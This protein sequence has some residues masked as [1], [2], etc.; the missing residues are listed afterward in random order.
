MH[1]TTDITPPTSKVKIGNFDA[2]T[3]TADEVVKSL[4]ENGGCFIRNLIDRETVTEMLNE[5]QP[6]LDAD[7]PWEGEFFP[8][9]TRRQ[10]MSPKV[11]IGVLTQKTGVNG[12]P[13][14]SPLYTQKVLAH[15]LYVEVSNRLLTTKS[16]SW[17][18]D[19]EEHYESLPQL[20]STSVFAI[21]PGARAQGLHRDDILHH[22]K[23]PKITAE[24]YTP[25]RD[26]ALGIFTAASKITT[27]NGATRF[28]PGSHLDDS[29]Y[30]PGDES[31]VVFAEMDPGDAFIMLASCYHGGNSIPFLRKISY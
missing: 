23:L 28:I 21:G 9:E 2:S 14:K 18:G 1:A 17:V 12:L 29:S 7:V 31:K 10:L 13:A 8:K 16:V 3:A 19:K 24:Q 6:Y 5:V 4:I 15:P 11:L 30:G 25:G 20:N 27:A 26:T 22:T